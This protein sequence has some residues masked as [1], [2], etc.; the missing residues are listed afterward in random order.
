MMLLFALALVVLT[1]F[2]Y[3]VSRSVIYPPLLFCVV[4]AVQMLGLRITGDYFF[5]M[6]DT[7]LWVFF[8]GALAFTIGGVLAL[9]LKLGPPKDEPD[10]QTLRYIDVILKISFLIGLLL[11]PLYWNYL[12]GLVG[13][14]DVANFWKE[15][16]MAVLEHAETDARDVNPILASIP[17][18]SLL[19]TISLYE[20]C[21]TGLGWLRASC[22]ILISL[23]YHL[24]STARSEVLIL[25]VSL[26][27]AVWFRS[28]KKALRWGSVA[29]CGF[30]VLFFFNQLKVEKAGSNAN[31]SVANNLPQ[32]ARGLAIYS[33]G[34]AVAFDGTVRNPGLIPNT[35][36]ITGYFT[37]ALNK[38]GF[39]LEDPV[40]FLQNIAVNTT[41]SINAYTIYFSYY[42][43]YGMFGTALFMASFGF[44]T[45]FVFRKAS[46]NDPVHVLL[47]GL[48]MYC[49]LT[50]FFADFFVLEMGFWFKAFAVGVIFYRIIPV[51]VKYK[52]R[53]AVSPVAIA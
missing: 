26:F 52:Q 35:F 1:V 41:F 37:R 42:T 6:E 36:P 33:L 27:A 5:P 51:I 4:W 21:R 15:L 23:I 14:G 39:Q 46:R 19:A 45:T 11:L 32:F 7:T 3:A 20:F 16:R 43:D 48:A 31:E 28:P 25:I 2:N 12:R 24:G 17:F 38:F 22:G 34:S 50:S 29:M 13:G 53:A 49:T 40:P 10:V 47:F 30:F 18:F 9:L 44:L 8:V